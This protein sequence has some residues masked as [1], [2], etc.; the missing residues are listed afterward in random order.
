MRV[1]R[2]TIIVLIGIVSIASVNQFIFQV[3]AILGLGSIAIL[4]LAGT[5]ILGLPLLQKQSV[6]FRPSTWLIVCLFLQ[7]ALLIQTT[8]ILGSVQQSWLILYA[9]AEITLLLSFCGLAYKLSKWLQQ[10]DTQTALTA[11]SPTLSPIPTLDEADTIIHNEMTRSRHHERPLAIIAFRLNNTQTDKYATDL[12]HDFNKYTIQ[13]TQQAQVVQH[14]YSQTQRYQQLVRDPQNDLLYL[15]CPETNHT[16][17]EKIGQ[18]ISKTIAGQT[19][20]TIHYASASFP[21]DGF[22]FNKIRKEAIKRMITTQS[23]MN[24]KA[25]Y[26]IL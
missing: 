7:I 16:S 1:L 8:G 21:E 4:F 12:P 14:L 23:D 5:T 25:H 24:D 10:L 15:I 3:P 17:A 9:I 26:T 19:N 18:Q 2:I 6:F 22:T 13:Q 11:V 20:I